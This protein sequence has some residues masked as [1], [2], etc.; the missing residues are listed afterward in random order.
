MED[1]DSAPCKYRPYLQL[2]QSVSAESP[3]ST[4][5]SSIVYRHD[6]LPIPTG[7]AVGIWRNVLVFHFVS[8]STLKRDR[9]TRFDLAKSGIVG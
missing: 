5:N 2:I 9:D 1:E 4:Q 6:F 3:T 8:T 7:S